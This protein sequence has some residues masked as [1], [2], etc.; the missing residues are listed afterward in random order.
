VRR[1]PDDGLLSM[2]PAVA[3]LV[4]TTVGFLALG[5]WLVERDDVTA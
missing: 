1:Q 3:V 5:A 2:G 4:A